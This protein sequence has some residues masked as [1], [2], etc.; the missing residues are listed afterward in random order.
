MN[1]SSVATYSVPEQEVIQG[2]EHPF[3]INLKFKYAKLDKI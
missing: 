2:T 3:K 1:E